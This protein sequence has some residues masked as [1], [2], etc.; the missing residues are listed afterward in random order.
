MLRHR[1]GRPAPWMV[2]AALVAGLAFV[3]TFTWL[4][5]RQA[6]RAAEV[7]TPLGP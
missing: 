1:P 3:G 5:C 4:Q 7:A 2:A 6:D